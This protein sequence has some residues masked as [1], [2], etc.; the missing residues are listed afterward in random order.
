[1]GEQSLW[2]E[3]GR[4]RGERL[5]ERTEG[6]AARLHLVEGGEA[7]LGIPGADEGGNVPCVA[8]TW[9][10]GSADRMGWDMLTECEHAGR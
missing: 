10:N 1:M 8:G 5:C 7:I 3:I 6:I 9:V 4:I 2:G